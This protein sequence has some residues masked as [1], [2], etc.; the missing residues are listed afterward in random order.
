MAWTFYPMSCLGAGKTGLAIGF[1][2]IASD[3]SVTQAFTTTGVAETSVPGNYV[4]TNGIS[5][6]DSFRGRIEWGTA[7]AKYAEEPVNPQTAEYL[8]VKV[9]TRS[10]Y[11]G[12]NVTV[13]GY[14]AGQDPA[15]LVLDVSA[16][17]HDVAGSI[18]DKINAA[19]AAS[20]PLTN[21][22]GDYASGTAGGA[23]QKIGTASVSVTSPV[24]QGGDVSIIQGDS[25]LAVDNRAVEWTDDGGTW[26]DLTGA[27]AL[28]ILHVNSG[29]SGLGLTV[30]TPSGPG[31]RLRLELT[32][33]ASGAM[34]S[35]TSPY[36]IRVVLADGSTVTL[37][38]GN[39]TVLPY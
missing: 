28:L 38:R 27:T 31:K 20:D 33:T 9:S 24:V 14:A 21:P 22:L 16:A 30:V 6:P 19:G 5:M 29:S 17:A 1:R 10:T 8:D 18:G 12:G 25:Y 36:S 7:G 39:W 4:V 37:A 11:A 3:G 32:A 13:G 35:R 26:P 15:T 34:T 23:L 2:L